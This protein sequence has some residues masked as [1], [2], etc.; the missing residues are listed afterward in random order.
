M[1]KLAKRLMTLSAALISAACSE[2]MTDV[3]PGVS[4]ALAQSRVERIS[5][6]RYELRF[7]IPS[8]EGADVS[9]H[10]SI[11]FELSNARSPLQIDYAQPKSKVHSLI[12]NGAVA[13]I[14]WVNEHIVVSSDVLRR[15]RNHIEIAF[16]AGSGSLNRNPG[17]L[18][19]LLVPDRA[20]TVFPL[21]DQPDLK[22]VY[23]LTLVLP[24][25]W[26]AL[27]NTPVDTV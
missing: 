20:R 12:V 11:S 1:W 21:F 25:A 8:D 7:D 26:R 19:T 13:E 17:F 24:A 6:L 10:A 9:A 23:Q 18:Y 5:Q 27:A 14:D 2:R 15:G 16:T 3:D 22:A 4:H